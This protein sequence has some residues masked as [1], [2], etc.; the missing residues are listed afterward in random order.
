MW[1]VLRTIFP[2]RIATLRSAG[3]AHSKNTFRFTSVTLG[4][5]LARTAI[6]FHGA[7]TVKAGELG[8]RSFPALF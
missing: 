5:K 1:I 7:V 3:A 4:A 2:F 8:T 6:S